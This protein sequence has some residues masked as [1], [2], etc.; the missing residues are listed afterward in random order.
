MYGFDQVEVTLGALSPDWPAFAAP[1]AQATVIGSVTR[2]RDGALAGIAVYLE[3][4]SAGTETLDHFEASLRREGWSPFDPPQP[5]SS[6]SAGFRSAPPM[7]G[8]MRLFC[9]TE[10]DPFLSV[11]V[12]ERAGRSEAVA[13]WDTGLDHHPLRQ[14]WAAYGPSGPLGHLIPDLAP[15]DGVPIQGGGG[16]GSDSEWDIRAR[17]RT[18]MPNSDLAT[19]YREQLARAGWTFRDSGG[20]TVV[21]WSRWKL[22]EDDY[23]GMLVVAEPLPETRDLTLSIR[24]PSRAARGWRMWGS[25]ARTFGYRG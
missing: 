6:G 12:S 17:A 3:D 16:G 5:G 9:R 18:S 25:S 20:D 15:P 4:V 19:H 2:R 23:E 11:H 14:H 22:A 21:Q 24:S 7:G 13:T 8:A 1:P 10:R